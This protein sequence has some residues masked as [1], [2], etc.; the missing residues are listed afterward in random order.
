MNMITISGRLGADPEMRVTPQ[1]KSVCS[2]RIAADDV[3]RDAP[4][5]WHTVSAWDK[6]AEFVGQYLVKGR[7]V[8][9]TGRLHVREWDDRETG[10]K[11]YAHEIVASLVEFMDSNPDRAGAG[12]DSQ[13][14]Q[15]RPQSGGGQ[16]GG[17]GGAGPGG[18][19]GYFDDQV[20]F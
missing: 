18:D 7:K 17:R 2:F 5:E 20:P 16:T 6:T 3:K 14:S 12:A 4:A 8:L 1:G 10:K 15:G 9:V 11:R 13:A 19:Q